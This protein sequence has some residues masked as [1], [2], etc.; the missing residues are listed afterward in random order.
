MDPSRYQLAHPGVGRVPII[1]V[2]FHFSYLYVI[3][4]V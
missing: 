2:F 4:K 1:L 3:V